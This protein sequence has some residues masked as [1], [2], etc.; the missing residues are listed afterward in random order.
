M[1]GPG[2]KLQMLVGA[3]YSFM[4]WASKAGRGVLGRQYFADQAAPACP[5]STGGSKQ[6]LLQVLHAQS[7]SAHI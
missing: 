5:L 7:D 4:L 2:P 3:I 6:C 1:M